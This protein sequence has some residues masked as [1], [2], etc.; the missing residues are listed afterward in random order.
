ML[1]L[2]SFV[3][4]GFNIDESLTT[5]NDNSEGA[6]SLLKAFECKNKDENSLQLEDSSRDVSNHIAGYISFKARIA[7]SN[8]CGYNLLTTDDDQKIFSSSYTALLSR[9]GLLSPREYLSD[10]VAQLFT[11]LDVCSTNIV[12]SKPP[13]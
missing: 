13:F 7:F 4:E 12:D 10:A 3:K 5:N 2:K 1:K 9:G 11:L 8:C 6:A